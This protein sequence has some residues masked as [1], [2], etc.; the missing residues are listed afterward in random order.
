MDVC[1]ISGFGL[2]WTRVAWRKDRL[3]V[4]YLVIFAVDT[5]GC[6]AFCRSLSRVLVVMMV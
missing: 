1:M 2:I 3:E 5:L 6:S 4:F